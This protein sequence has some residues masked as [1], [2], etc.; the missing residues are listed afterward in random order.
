M[1]NAVMIILVLFD[2]TGPYFLGSLHEL[3]R[4]TVQ[5]GQGQYTV[6]MRRQYVTLRRRNY[7]QSNAFIGAHAQTVP[8]K[9]LANPKPLLI[10]IR[11]H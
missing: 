5:C 9:V 2:L 10:H 8:I 4:P 3:L 6:R 7:S 1:I 11:R